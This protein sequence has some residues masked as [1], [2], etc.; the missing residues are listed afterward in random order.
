MI[1]DADELATVRPL[2]CVDSAEG[3]A[4]R[5]RRPGGGTCVRAWW[6]LELSD[7]LL[8]IGMTVVE[9]S[10]ARGTWCE[11]VYEYHGAKSRRQ[12][13]VRHCCGKFVGVDLEQLP[14]ASEV[15]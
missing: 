12:L 10:L 1:M 9:K 4:L 14:L 11:W 6:D 2:L 3:L 8:A 7:M 13:G 15:C 5:D